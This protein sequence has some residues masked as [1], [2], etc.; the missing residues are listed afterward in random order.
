MS[1][2]EDAILRTVIYADIFQFPLN[3]RELHHYLIADQPVSRAQVDAALD[4]SSFLR[5]ELEIGS[6]YVICA[7]RQSLISLRAERDQASALLWSPALTYAR[8][9][10]RLP[11]VRMVA[12]TGALAVRNAWAEDDDLDYVLVTAAGRV[13]VGARLRHFAGAAGEAARHGGLP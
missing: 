3:R 4:S 9:L 13:L 5:Q 7:G 12:L 6:E 10:A 8:W 2:I 11:F 1:P